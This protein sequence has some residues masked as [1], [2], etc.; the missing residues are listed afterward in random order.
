MTS[1]EALE[2]LRED[3][4]DNDFD[5]KYIKRIY[6]TIKQDLERLEVLEKDNK[7][8]KDFWL[9]T[10]N[11]LV[12]VETENE[13]LKDSIKIKQK[14]VN[15]CIDT[16]TQENEQLKKCIEEIFEYA[17]CE[18]DSIEVVD[19]IERILIEVLENDK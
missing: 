3:L 6:N 7:R 9:E 8:L 2:E 13:Q 16:L 4:E 5:K 15:K 1:K 11:K 12:T 18:L 14:Q 19:K 17:K 10:T